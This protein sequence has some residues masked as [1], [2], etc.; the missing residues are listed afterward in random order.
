VISIPPVAAVPESVT[1]TSRVLPP[2][3]VVIET[4]ALAIVAGVTVRVA[5]F[6]PPPALAEMAAETEADT[7]VVVIWNAALV[8]PAAM[9]TVSGTTA[10]AELLASTTV[11]P[12]LG[13]GPDRATVPVALLPPT[14]D[15]GLSVTRE[16][17]VGPIERDAVLLAPP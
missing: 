8:A 7:G 14:T 9:A 16:T 13:A 2:I 11:R 3:T 4:A 17:A 10:L 6:V 15:A 12:P 1:V 5:D